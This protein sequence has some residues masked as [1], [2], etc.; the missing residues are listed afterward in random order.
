MFNEQE[1]F[2]EDSPVDIEIDEELPAPD[3]D[4][5]PATDTYVPSPRRV[6]E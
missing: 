4:P 5:A 6:Q 2:E 3:T 1:E